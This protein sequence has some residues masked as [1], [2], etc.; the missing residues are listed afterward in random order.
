MRDHPA[1][2]A[3]MDRLKSLQRLRGRLEQSMPVRLTH[4]DIT[5]KLG[6]A[7]IPTGV[8]RDF[9]IE[10]FGLETQPDHN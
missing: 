2:P 5:A 10:T 6:S 4:N 7:W 1:E 9:M 3:D 8:I